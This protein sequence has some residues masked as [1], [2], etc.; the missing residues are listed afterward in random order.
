MEGLADWVFEEGKKGVCARTQQFRRFF[1]EINRQLNEIC[2]GW[3][4]SIDNKCAYWASSKWKEILEIYKYQAFLEK[5]HSKIKTWQ[6]ATP[7]LLKKGERV[8]AYLHLHVIALMIF[9]LLSASWK[10]HLKKIKLI[11]CHFIQKAGIAQPHRWTTWYELLKMLK[12]MKQS[13]AKS[14]RLSSSTD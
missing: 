5:N 14:Y 12:D 9:A 10:K 4:F 1:Q 2:H 8:V 3:N 13:N 11:I 6:E 7:V